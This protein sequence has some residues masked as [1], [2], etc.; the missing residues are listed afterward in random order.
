[1]RKA[2]LPAVR[3]HRGSA[4]CVGRGDGEDEIAVLNERP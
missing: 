4:L 2:D 3:R 1:M